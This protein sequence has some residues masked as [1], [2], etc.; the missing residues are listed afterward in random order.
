MSTMKCKNKLKRKTNMNFIIF[1]LEWNQASNEAD[2]NKK[3]L[4]FE[5]IE[6]GAVKLDSHKNQIGSFSKLIKPYVY[7]K[8][9]PITKKMLH[10]QVEDLNKEDDFVDCMNEFLEWCGKDYTFCT[11]GVLDLL[12]L[13]R[14]M[15]YYYMNLL[16]NGPLKYLDIQKLFSLEFE[17]GK[18]R[19]TLE[20]AVDLLKIEK[21]IPFH[22]AYSDAYYTAKVFSEIKNPAVE[23]KYSFDVFTPPKTKKD[24]IKIVF[25]TYEKYISR[26]FEDKNAAMDDRE[27]MSTKCFYCHK[28]IKKKIKWFTVNGKHFLSLSYCDVHG[29]MK[30]KIRIKKSEDDFTYVIKTSKFIPK[31]DA[32]E[33][34]EK[35]HKYKKGKPSQT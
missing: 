21:D 31:E 7:T 14:N 13:Q 3:I 33:L 22:R 17:D 19:R 28:N 20:H 15:K 6:I 2:P 8:M 4:P 35:Y 23:S 16:S 27:V 5:V 26:T 25:D 12:E 29:P 34:I 11:W 18:S 9:H 1:D 24:E 10:L 30:S 32:D